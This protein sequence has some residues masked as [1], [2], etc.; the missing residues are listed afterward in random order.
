MR[1]CLNPGG[2]KV[3]LRILRDP[4]FTA[5]LLNHVNNVQ[6]RLSVPV[7]A[8]LSACLSFSSSQL[9]LLVLPTE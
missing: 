7:C 8:C 3:A 4:L 9:R 1:A 5:G 6:V 2:E